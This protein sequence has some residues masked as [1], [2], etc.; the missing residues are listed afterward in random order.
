MEEMKESRFRRLRRQNENRKRTR[1]HRI[2]ESVTDEIDQFGGAT[3]MGDV[4]EIDED[5]LINV[6]AD[7]LGRVKSIGSAAPTVVESHRRN[8]AKKSAQVSPL[9]SEARK[10]KSRLLRES[11]RGDHRSRS[12]DRRY[13]ATPVTANRNVNKSASSVSNKRLSE[14]VA[15]NL[16]LKRE[17]NEMNLFSAKLLYVNKIFNGKNATAKQRR[18]IVEAMDNAKTLR[19]AKLLYHSILKSLDKKSKTNLSE[20]RVRVLGS[21]SRTTPSAQPTNNGVETDRW[22]VLA[23]IEEKK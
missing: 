7:E 18:A 13:V 17:L 8:R 4:F 23:G 19:E 21:S 15:Q 11:S 3:S 9:V 10:L 6:L 16:R 20:N 12:N 14:A 2:L 5:T 22:A 1:G